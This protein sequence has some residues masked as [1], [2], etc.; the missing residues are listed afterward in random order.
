MIDTIKLN[1]PSTM[2]G[3]LHRDK[4]ERDLMNA[5]RGFAKLVQNPTVAELKRGIYKPRLT[6][7]HRFN[8]Y[9][10]SEETLT[11]EFS[12]PKM[13]FGNNFD[14]L[15]DDDLQ[16]LLIKLNQTLK[17]MGVYTFERNLATARVS[18]I[19]LAKNIPLTDFS[20]P[21]TYIKQLEKVNFNA[22]LDVSKT[23]YINGGSGIKAH[24]NSYEIAFYDKLQ[25]LK[26][27]KKS[28]RRAYERDSELQ[29]HLFEEISKKKPFEVFRMEVRIGNRRK[30]KQ[31]L[32]KT[33]VDDEP[34]FEGMFK[35]NTA[36][37]VL[38]YYLEL[39]EEGYLPILAYEYENPQKF[40]T[41]FLLNNPDKRYTSAFKYVGMRVMLDY[42]NT[43]EFRQ[44]LDRYSPNLWYSLNKDMKT[45][46]HTDDIDTLKLLKDKVANYEPLNLV[47]FQ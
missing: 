44:L 43:R 24:A 8:T 18:S 34:T 25:D 3:Q 30:L 4:F 20:T 42:M 11:I 17:L 36:Q 14:E 22:I 47:D 28:P 7:S 41:N 27:A 38:L 21:Y 40:F 9:G 31:V 15:T 2:I 10:K 6:L 46:K 16:P 1:L 5:T 33:E 12:A 26:K 32:L 37:K 23:D 29:L 19:H 39:I 45:L 35:Q 13:L